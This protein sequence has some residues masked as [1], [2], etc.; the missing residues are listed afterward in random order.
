[1]LLDSFS[2]NVHPALISLYLLAAVSA[3]VGDLGP[4]HTQP[5]NVR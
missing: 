4:M 5:A 1:M 3:L 2:Q